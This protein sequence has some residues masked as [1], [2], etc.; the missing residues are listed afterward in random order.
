MTPILEAC[1]TTLD[2][3][4]NA[5][6]NGASR[7]EVC[8]RLDVDGLT[9][10]IAFVSNI[11]QEIK[12]PVRVLVRPRS[13]NFI[14]TPEEKN[15]YLEQIRKVINLSVEG[16]VIGALT[17]DYIPDVPFLAKVRSITSQKIC[18]HKAIDKCPDILS[19]TTLLVHNG[20]VDSI[21]SSGG[22]ETAQEGVDN[23][24]RMKCIC[25]TKVELVA[26]GKITRENRNSIHSSLNLNAYHGR[27]IC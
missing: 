24:L 13:G 16:I 12:V 5:V 8:T 10:G 19:A 3:A 9:P 27:I 25:S 14:Y 22:K 26:A 7:L 20:C 6:T 18:F 23:L 17:T 4:R 2:Q 1:V 21:L 15:T 11:L